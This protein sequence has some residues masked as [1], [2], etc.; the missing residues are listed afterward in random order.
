MP[1]HSFESFCAGAPMT[2]MGGA[3]A[4][5]WRDL[6][7][8]RRALLLAALALGPAACGDDSNGTPDA[9]PVEPAL[10]PGCAGQPVPPTTLACT[11]LYVDIASKQLNTGVEAFTP[12]V[13]LWSDGTDKQR[14]IR[15]PPGTII[16]NTDPNEWVFPIG[17]RLWKQ[18]S[19]GGKRIET[20]L[21]HKVRTNN[22]V[23]ATYAWNADD[24]AAARTPGGD[25]PI[26]GGTYHIPTG[27][28]CDKCHKGRSERILGFEHVELGL[29]GAQGLTLAKLIERKLLKVPPATA[30]LAIGDDGTG[31]AA[32][33]LGW[34]HANCGITCHNGN[35][36]SVAFQAGMRL[37]LDPRQLDGRPLLESDPRRTTTGI[38]VNAVN[39]N[40][41]T[42]I[43]P[44]DP[45]ASLLYQLISNRGEGNQMPPIAS[46]VV[47]VTNVALIKDWIVRMAPPPPPPDAGVPDAAEPVD[48]AMPPPDPVD[49]APPEDAVAADLPQPPEPD[50]APPP[51]DAGAPP[52]IDAAMP[53]DPA[54]A[55][56]PDLAPP[57]ADTERV[58]SEI[59]LAPAA[60]S[61]AGSP[62][63]AAVEVPPAVPPS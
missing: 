36:S 7:Q 15:L 17:T 44:G 20:R 53:V 18:F 16:D 48:T 27:D 51:V 9:G 60:A 14:W 37:R 4:P 13:P 19:V 49:T 54:D 47:D 52:E 24:S 1:P 25:V 38:K 21:W 40:G 28:E 61:D 50:L 63:D 23:A 56:A 32:P 43:I 58:P 57:P 45:E 30:T 39:W 22:W 34:L 10:P 3:R 33:A 8:G 2:T 29:P 59:D 26:A 42:R 6:R 55:A 12:A 62:E 31:V 35:S 5:F 11:G 46:R 41:R